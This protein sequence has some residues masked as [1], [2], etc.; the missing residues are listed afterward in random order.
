MQKTLGIHFSYLHT[1][2]SDSLE[3]CK[4]GNKKSSGHDGSRVVLRVLTKSTADINQ[5]LL[6]IT[7]IGDAPFM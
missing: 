4:E 7:L 1:S 2:L 3:I 5:T 6:L